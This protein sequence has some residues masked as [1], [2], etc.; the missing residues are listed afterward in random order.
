[1][2]QY[3]HVY[4][5]WPNMDL[6]HCDAVWT[7]QLSVTPPQYE[8]R[9]GVVTWPP[10]PQLGRDYEPASYYA[11]DL[12]QPEPSPY[13][14]SR[15]GYGNFDSW[16]ADTSGSVLSYQ[17]PYLDP[18]MVYKLR[19]I[20]YH[21]GKDTW[22]IA[23]RCD[24]GPQ[25]RVHVGPNVPDTFWLEVPK[26]LYRDARI[27]VD[28]ARVSGD[29]VS[30]AGL[31]LYQLEPEPDG[32]EGV[33]S[34]AGVPNTRLLTCTPNPL[35]RATTISYELASAGPVAITVHDVSGRLVRRI[36]SGSRSAGAQA[37]TWDGTDDRGRAVPAGVYFV[38]FNAN[39]ET[40]SRR[41]TL[42][43]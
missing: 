31:K 43:R 9:F 7:E 16:N 19:A 10:G 26:E 37:V 33:Q 13:C 15:G 23:L 38:R 30:L 14:L 2:S 35:G 42:V 12:G 3:P 25:H 34:A 22:D 27:A 21:P 20:L 6:F 29:Y 1:M 11:V 36:E 39:G 28:I 8:V 17:L 5:Y 40:A 4:C 41:V 18:R 24:S 32:R